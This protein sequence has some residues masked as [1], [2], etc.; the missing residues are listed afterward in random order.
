[1]ATFLD[2]TGLEQFSK[3]FVF[4]FVWL[5]VY[6]LLSYTKIIQNHA[7]NI[8]IGMILALF[9]LFSPI[10]TGAIIHIA[11]WFAVALIFMMLFGVLASSFGGSELAQY[12]HLKSILMILVIGALII[13]IFSYIRE[14]TIVPGD[15]GGEQDFTKT[16]NVIFHPKVIGIVFISLLSVFTIVLLA[17]KT[18]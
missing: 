7:I 4:I 8:I 15:E 9:V 13:G 2:I 5:G 10:V 1:M 14:Q 3:F 18:S 6:S 12:S 17:G 11:P 16:T